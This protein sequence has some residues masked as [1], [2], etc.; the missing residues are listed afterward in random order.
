MINYYDSIYYVFDILKCEILI[1]I[2]TEHIHKNIRR[3]YSLAKIHMTYNFC[4]GILKFLISGV[5]RI[6]VRGGHLATKRLARAPPPLRGSGG[7]GPRT[8]AKFKPLKQV[9]ELEN[10]SIFQKYQHFSC[11]KNQFLQRKL[12]K[13]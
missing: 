3:K 2:Y 11:P 10:E 8:V 1:P 6:L 9:K 5:G 4:L 13:N 7:E 12:S